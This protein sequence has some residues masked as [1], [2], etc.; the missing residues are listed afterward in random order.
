MDILTDLYGPFFDINNWKTVLGSG[1]DWLVIFSLVMIECILS[2]DNAVVLATQTQ[3][4]KDQKE[5][6]KSLF[7]GLW[8]AYLF[9][10]IVI[11]IGTYLINLWEIKVIGALY[12]A[13]LV[14]RFF[15][16][17]KLGRQTRKLVKKEGKISIFWRVVIQIEF[18]DIVFSVDSVLASLA[19]SSN[20]VIV[21]I[22]GLIGI[23]AMRG[24]AEVIMGMMQKIPELE[25]MAYVLIAIIALKLL[26]SIPMIDIEIP[27][28]IFALIV[29]LAFIITIGIHYLRKPVK[30]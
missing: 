10:F 9:R 23:L 30:K 12:L 28:G 7:Y 8:G 13:Y 24:I 3:V 5:R 16:K 6:E 25:T 21:L 18:M 26:L 1:S 2:V 14:F 4:L 22:G 19:I 17:Q 29:I 11:G 15:D 20:P 27:S